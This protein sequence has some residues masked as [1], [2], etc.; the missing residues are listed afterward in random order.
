[1]ITKPDVGLVCT[2]T[3]FLPVIIEIGQAPGGYGL[4]GEAKY[5]HTSREILDVLVGAVNKKGL[6]ST[7]RN[8]ITVL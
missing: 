8:G 3:V 1:M 7:G 5:F 6:G 2:I 4:A